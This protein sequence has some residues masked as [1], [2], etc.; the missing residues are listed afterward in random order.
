MHPVGTWFENTKTK[1]LGRLLRVA[2][3]DT[4][5]TRLL[6]D[7]WLQPGAAVIGEH[8]HDPDERFSVVTGTSACVFAG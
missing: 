6:A 4:G 8:V 1:E 7:L 2:P 3:Q 5:G